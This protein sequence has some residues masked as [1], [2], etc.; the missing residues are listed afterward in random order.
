M[1]RTTT[2]SS[3]AAMRTAAVGLSPKMVVRSRTDERG[4]ADAPSSRLSV[5]TLPLALPPALPDGAVVD[6]EP[7]ETAPRSPDEV[8]VPDAE[9]VALPPPVPD[10]AVVLGAAGELPVLLLPWA[11]VS[12]AGAARTLAWF[13]S[14]FRSISRPTSRSRCLRSPIST[15]T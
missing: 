1:A 10:G 12:A 9:P 8:V 13:I 11:N 4:R 6:D 5:L 14:S 15:K 7:D 2:R 3:A